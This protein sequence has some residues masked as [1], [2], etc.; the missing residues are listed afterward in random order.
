MT[1]V[2]LFHDGGSVSH[3]DPYPDSLN[4]LE[5]RT[6]YFELNGF[7]TSGGYDDAFVDFA[8]GPLSFRLP[9]TQARLRAVRYHDLHHVVTG[10]ETTA[11]GEFEISA[12]EL[13]AGCRDFWAAWVLN[14][15]GLAAGLLSMPRRTWRAF[16]RGRHSRSL[17][18]EELATLLGE[19]VGQV[20]ARTGLDHA[21]AAGARASD[22]SLFVL[23]ALVG[24]II[25]SVL[26]VVGALFALPLLLAKG[27]RAATGGLTRG[28]R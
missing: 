16:L 18:N 5:A 8:L 21:G 6:R 2:I 26:L 27:L 1:V 14:L 13:G 17:Y 7:G 9:N 10:Y 3:Q 22:L 4:M 20:R 28:A 23:S 12:W 11:R 24:A 15:G 25:G 19:N